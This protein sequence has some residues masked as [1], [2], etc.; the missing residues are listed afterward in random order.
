VS[1]GAVASETAAERTVRDL[2]RLRRHYAAAAEGA[3][4]EAGDAGLEAGLGGG[5]ALLVP[6]H[7]RLSEWG[8][9]IGS[10][11]I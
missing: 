2:K 8:C 1:A 4:L 11:Q 10:K 9:C 6:V 5:A 7:V 3:G